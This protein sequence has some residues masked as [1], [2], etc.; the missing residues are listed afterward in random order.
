M[1]LSIQK[2]I[3][4]KSFDTKEQKKENPKSLLQ[5]E[6]FCFFLKTQKLSFIFFRNMK[7]QFN[8]LLIHE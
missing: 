8:E 4:Q 6:D 3:R 1:F 7:I 5:A 2:Y